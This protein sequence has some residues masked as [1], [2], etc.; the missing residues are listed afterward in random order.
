MPAYISMQEQEFNPIIVPSQ[1]TLTIDHQHIT[2]S[3]IARKMEQ[4]KLLYQTNLEHIINSK[5]GEITEDE[6]KT[7]IE[8]IEDI[9]Q[10]LEKPY[11]LSMVNNQHVVYLSNACKLKRK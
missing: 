4:R 8:A 11:K 7:T 9:I 5:K 10:E 6:K 1:S 2:S 3:Y